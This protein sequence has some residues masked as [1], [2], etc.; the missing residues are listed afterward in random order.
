MNLAKVMAEFYT[1]GA[2]S[3]YGAAGLEELVGNPNN[4]VVDISDNPFLESV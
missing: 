4:V 3:A 1:N 2:F